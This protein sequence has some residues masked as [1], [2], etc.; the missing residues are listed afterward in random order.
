MVMNKNRHF[1]AHLDMIAQVYF[2]NVYICIL[3]TC[4]CTQYINDL[5][6]IYN[7]SVLLTLKEKSISLLVI[8]DDD[9]YLNALHDW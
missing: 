5:V 3:N 7:L 4:K 9:V 6:Y 8:D 1:C 2:Q